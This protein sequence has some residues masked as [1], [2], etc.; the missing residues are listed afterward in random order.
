MDWTKVLEGIATAS[1]LA[2]ALGYALTVVWTK[3]QS[4]DLELAA[5]DI[6]HQK[7]IDAKDAEIAR[8]NAE[9]HEF[10]QTLLLKTKP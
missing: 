9:H 6:A 5:K 2:G 1:P 3:L 10:V 7:A 8:L 4:K